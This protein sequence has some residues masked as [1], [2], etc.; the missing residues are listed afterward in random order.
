VLTSQQLARVRNVLSQL[1]CS[2]FT[3]GL[4][5]ALRLVESRLEIELEQTTTLHVD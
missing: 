3:A 2:D 5:R 4:Q 1:E